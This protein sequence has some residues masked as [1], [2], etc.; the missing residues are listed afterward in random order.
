M[1]SIAFVWS[2]LACAGHGRRVQTSMTQSS[3]DTLPAKVDVAHSSHSLLETEA[4]FLPSPSRGVHPH[5]GSVSS[6]PVSATVQRELSSHRAPQMSTIAVNN[7][8]KGGS[9]TSFAAASN[10]L[11]ARDSPATP[12]AAA[13]NE[14]V[15]QHVAKDLQVGMPEPSSKGRESWYAN[16]RIPLLG[17]GIGIGGLAVASM[18]GK[19]ARRSAEP[20]MS[21]SFKRREE[22][23]KVLQE[24]QAHFVSQLEAVSAD[25]VS[26][27]G[28]FAPSSWERDEGTHGGGTRYGVVETPV[29]NRASVNYSGVFYDDA[30]EKPVLSATALSVIIHPQNPN[31]PSM[32]CHFSYTE[33]RKGD[34]Y[35]RMISDL[36]PSL[37]N[38]D[39]KNKFEKALKE[40]CPQQLFDDGKLFGDKYFFIPELNMYR[41]TSHLFIPHLP[42]GKMEASASRDL[43]KR[44]ATTTIDTYTS[45][46][47][48]RM[49]ASPKETVTERQKKDQLAYHTAYFYQ[50]LFLDRGTTAGIM[51]HSDNDVGTLASLPSYIDRELLEFW[52]KNKVQP[53]HDELLRRILELL[54]EGDG[55]CEVTNEIRGQLAKTCRSYYLEDKSRAQ[56]QADMDVEGWKKSQA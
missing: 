33:P 56:F 30:P 48:E 16:L 54:P 8:A 2:L 6:H 39:A 22:S 25:G 5:V 15:E 41:G 19:L 29:F 12:F 11:K 9:A 4:A 18:I 49:D 10:D 13:S 21:F 14:L 34:P 40:K 7:E 32:H 46:I 44:L 37:H 35:W 55:P 28:A 31:A 43:A 17:C 27:K 38:P 24:V 52:L 50:V 3:S 53:P 36:N 42:D 26:S 51:A 45:I 1:R 20:R 23:Q 47:Q